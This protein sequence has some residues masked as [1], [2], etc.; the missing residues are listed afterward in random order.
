MKNFF[1]RFFGKKD[2]TKKSVGP[3]PDD[4][5]IYRS[6]R[7]L[8]ASQDSMEVAD[9]YS[10]SVWVYSSVNTIAQ[11]ISGVPWRIYTEK[12]DNLKKIIEEGALYELFMNPNPFT[13]C[14]QLFY[15]TILFME[16]YGEAFWV[17]DG[18]NNNSEIPKA[19]WAPSPLRFEP[20]ID[21]ETRVFT[22]AWKYRVGTKQEEI[23]PPHKIIHFR[24]INPY[25][26]IRG[27]SGIEASKLG[28]EQDYFA[29]QYNKNFFKNGCKVEGFISVPDSLTDEQFDRLIGQFEERHQGYDRAHK[30]GVIEGGAEYQQAGRTQKDMEF[31][32]LKT[33]ARGEILAAFHTNE[34]VLGIYDNIQCAPAGTEIMTVNGFVPIEL[35]R[36]GDK[37]ASLNDGKAYFKEVT[38]TYEYD[39]EGLLYTQQK[40]KVN[41]RTCASRI[42]FMLSPEHKMFGKE[43]KYENVGGVY[44]SDEFVFKRISEIKPKSFVS[45]RNAEWSGDLIDSFT[46]KDEDKETV[47]EA[48]TWLKFLGWFIS[49]GHIQGKHELGITQIKSEGQIKLEEDLKD[50]PLNIRKYDN[51]RYIVSGKHLRDY[52]VENIGYYCHEKHIPREILNLHPSLL[53]YLFESLMEGDGTKVNKGYHYTTTSKQLANDVF[54]LSVRLGYAP[55]LYGGETGKDRT[56]EETFPNPKPLWIVSIPS[57]EDSS[58]MAAIKPEPVEFKGKLYCVEVPPYHTMMIR[59]NG[60]VIWTGNSY[61]GISNARRA[62]WDECL[63]PKMELIEDVLWSKFFSRIDG[64]RSWGGFDSDKVRALAEDLKTKVEVAERLTKIGFPPN[65]INK[66]LDL[67]FSDVK[68]GDDWWVP[69]S[70]VPASMALENS[71]QTVTN[72]TSPNKPKN[73]DKT[74]D[75]PKD[76]NKSGLYEITNRDDA[77]WSNFISRESQIEKI[78][79]GKLKRY[80]FEQRSRVLEKIY[81]KEYT[82]IFDKEGEQ[83]KLGKVLS[84]MYKVVALAGAETI[85]EELVIEINKEDVDKI[86]LSII[87]RQATLVVPLI[88]ETMKKQ[89]IN[90][91]KDISDNNITP[92]EIADKVREVYNK[93]TNRAGT[94]ARTE[95]ASIMNSIRVS[96]M[97]NSGFEFHKWITSKSDRK[98]TSHKDL[99]GNIV[100]I[101]ESFSFDCILRYPCDHQAPANEV[102][103][104]LCVTTPVIRKK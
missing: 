92:N 99:N 69:V 47:F 86:A 20:V 74:D 12:K 58:R 17:L 53:K 52:L 19:I 68:W 95:T 36:I 38:K 71:S 70:L 44:K 35:I 30:L 2:T 9:P 103:N 77:V 32:S 55:T 79:K 67:G 6:L 94:I 76:D 62:F 61:E 91:I 7:S 54:E 60:K 31:N 83:E 28:V 85:G 90:S 25:D 11:S 3:L 97:K 84:Q 14:K 29:S 78:F 93:M 24:Y 63:L 98:R 66:R 23:L 101:G 102:I 72:N 15:G 40:S 16:L 64:G 21:K 37:I 75:K 87:E 10:K 22:G 88:I 49:E 48:K 65:E 56:N 45:P 50:F 42:D 26:D 18:R 51:C 96:Y 41:G 46:I 13:T 27:L 59:Y 81:K 89:L 8:M 100:R 57:I 82:S 73:D 104:C 34:V 39:Y 4:S 33:M 43:R 5:R 1:S 80:M